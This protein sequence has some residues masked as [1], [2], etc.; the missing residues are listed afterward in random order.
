MEVYKTEMQHHGVVYQQVNA[1]GQAAMKSALL[2]NGGASVAMLAFIGTAM[3]NG[4]D[5]T[6]LLKLCFSMLM[7]VAGT[8]SVAMA[9][10]VTYLGGL[11]DS[12]TND[13]EEQSGKKTFN[14]WPI[15]NAIAIILV[16][17]SYILFAAGSLNAHCAFTG[18]LS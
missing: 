9:C 13:T 12:A 1:Q 11:A 2:I 14:W 10:G 16:V 8:L 17:I 5:D 7:F 3:N 15:L 4:T 6:M 18:S